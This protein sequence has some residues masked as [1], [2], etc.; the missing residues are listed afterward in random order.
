[1]IIQNGQVINGP[2]WPEPVKVDLVEEKGNFFRI[3]GAM[4]NSQKHVDQL[5]LKTDLESITNLEVKPLFT[6]NPRDFFLAL[7]TYRYRFASLYDPLLAINT[8]KVDPLPHQIDAVY[9]KVL[10]FPRIR[11]L[12]A[13]DPGAGKTIMAGLII[14]EMKLR[15]LISRILIVTP[16]HL[17]DQWRREMKDRFEETFV[18]VDRSIM[19]AFYG[20]NVWSKEPQIITSIDF[21]KQE[22]IINSIASTHYDL[23]VVD[24]AHKMSAYRYGKKLDK[25]IRYRLGERLS[26]ICTHF[27][28]L[29]A[30]PHHGDPESFRLFLD[31]LDPGFFATTDLVAESIRKQENPLFI[32]RVKEDLKDFEGKPLF[33]PRHVETKQ[34]SL[35]IES[36]VEQELYNELSHYVIEQYNKALNRDKRRN[37]AFALVILQ[38]R[39]AS[40]TYALL[41]SLERRKQKLESILDT[42]DKQKA[43]IGSDYDLEEVEDL[44]EEDRWKFEEIWETLSVAENRQELEGELD[45]LDDLI[46]RAKLIANADPPKEVKL[47]H[48]KAAMS[49]LKRDFPDSKVLIF[50]ESKDTLD[51]LEKNLKRWNYNVCTIHGGM[52]LEERIKAELIFKNDAQVLVATEAAGE[53]INLQFCNLMINYDIPWNPNR[54]EQRM[55]R[56]HRYGQTKE[57]YIFNLVASDTREGQVLTKLFKKLDEIRQALGNDKVFDVLGDIIQGQDLAQLMLDAAASARGMD[58]ILKDLEIKIDPEYV[59][60][61]RDEL[62]ESLATHYIDYT[63]IKDMADRAREYRLIP[64]YTEAFFNKVLNT[65][66]VKWNKK[67][68]KAYPSGSFLSIESVPSVFKHLA[69]EVDFSK[70]YG[71]LLRRY[72]LVTFDK[73][74]SMRVPTAELV[75]FGDPLFEAA[76]LWVERNL[77]T[78]LQEGAVFTDPDGIMNGVLLFY[79]GEVKDGKNEVAGTRLFALFADRLTGNINVVNPAILWDLQE[80]GKE[81]MTAISLEIIRSQALSYLLPEL[82]TYRQKLLKERNHQA[83][84]KEKYGLKSLETLN[85]NLDGDLINLQIRQDQGEKVDIVI[86]NKK[87][88]KEH[89]ELAINE[90]VKN[91]KQE[92]SLTISMPWFLGAARILPAASAPQMENDP[93]AEQI[94]M[95]RALSF[96]KENGRKPEDVSTQNLGFDIR[97]IGED[98]QKRFIEVKGRTGS[99]PVALTQNEWFKA[100][101]FQNDYFLYVVLNTGSNQDLFVIQNPT[102]VLKSEEQYDVRFLV[103]LKEIKSK[104]VHA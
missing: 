45:T 28:F 21:A 48:L 11:Y 88:Q 73:D 22:E 70:R 43:I 3:V 62:G 77:E 33:L 38:R 82:E 84:I 46:K 14:K 47:Q 12:I 37:V 101:R 76:L 53:G 49:D 87:E 58:E 41:K 9:G 61:L 20:E 31:L 100:Q 59:S 51:Y 44:D 64:E 27:L 1:M 71:P 90:L 83:E 96:E 75:T 85:I 8:S 63:R 65:L 4:V 104:G 92:R 56:I 40:S 66:G 18:V 36:P 98:C 55:G 23:I 30:T 15:H 50:T 79:R 10:Q 17:K 102:I 67:T 93:K 24:E 81:D 54:L 39:L 103:P 16:G 60:Q 78:S 2:Q 13:D 57:V 74:A 34:F 80:G 89:Y 19:G 86:R 69:D 6:A 35:K 91:L 97:S 95:Q 42:V 99:G 94:A 68:E 52:G 25:T 32:R 7:E 29:T 72:P 26:Q 5:I